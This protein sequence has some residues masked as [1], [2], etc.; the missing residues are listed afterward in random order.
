M[1]APLIFS[2][3]SHS[4]NVQKVF[5][6]VDGFFFFS[7]ADNFN[8]RSSRLSF[9]KLS[10]YAAQS[11]KLNMSANLFFS[12]SLLVEAVIFWGRT[13]TKQGS[14]HEKYVINGHFTTFTFFLWLCFGTWFSLFFLETVEIVSLELLPHFFCSTLTNST[15][16]HWASRIGW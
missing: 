16:M 12:T 11:R 4:I 14:T 1:K 2:S 15:S 9:Q 8:Y 10:T 6:N 5:E 13:N 3:T 7:D